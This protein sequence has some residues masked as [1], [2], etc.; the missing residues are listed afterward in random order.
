VN[1]TTVVAESGGLKVVAYPGDQ[2]ILLAMSLADELV[3]PDKN[4]AGFAIWRSVGGKESPLPNRLGFRP[5]TAQ[6]ARTAAGHGWTPS[7]QA[8]F[9]KFRWID[10][11][12]DGFAAPIGYRVRALFFTGQA[13]ATA[14]G[15]EVSLTV[16]PVLQ[17]HARFRPAFTRGYIASQAYADKFGVRDIRPKGAHQP[18]FDTAPFEAQYRWLGAD[19][20]VRLFDFLADCEQDTSARLDAF[21]YDCDE[22]DAIA[23]LCRLGREGRLR[24]IF[25]NA[26]LHTK[27]GAAEVA[28]A[29]LL[30]AAA[31]RAGVKRGHF[32]RFQHNKV[33]IKR[34]RASG[35]AQRVFFGSMNFSV[36][37]LYVQANNVMVADDARIAGMFADAFDAAWQDDVKT[38]PFRT[39]AIAQGWLTGS[40]TGTADLPRCW[41]AFSPHQDAAQSLGA[42]ADRVRHA[43]SSVLFAVME[44]TGT[45]PVL[46]SLRHIAEQPTVFSY[47]TVETDGGLAVQKPSGQMGAFTGFAALTR[48]VP[49]PFHR[50]FSGGAGMHIHDKYVVVDFNGAAPTVFTGS[51]NLAA[52]GEEANGDHLIEIADEAIANMYAIEAVAMFDHYHFRQNMKT[53]QATKPPTPLTLWY[54]GKP[55]QPQPWWREY[56]DPACIQLRDRC[57]FAKVPL[58]DGVPTTKTVDWASVD[59]EA[60]RAARPTPRTRKKT[61]PRRRG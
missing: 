30:V 44:P 15:P 20:R 18:D 43:T 58:P 13:L 52:G 61:T 60:A 57:L 22:P 40:A 39:S 8:P 37:G 7:D 27:P 38:A 49:P 32:S 16:A 31:G 54:P 5:P 17:T 55:N 10:V 2:K 29:S 47:G 3:G 59:R 41:L 25:D 9:Q 11:P 50:E 12:P 1:A 34:D 45:G 46:V 48:N 26:A 14:P 56:Y 51:S 6:A 35:K 28:T 19:A 21:V 23:A 42:I 4:L 24:V 33:L 36:R 53:A